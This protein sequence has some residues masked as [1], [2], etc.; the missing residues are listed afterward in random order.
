M[1]KSMQEQLSGICASA[2]ALALELASGLGDRIEAAKRGVPAHRYEAQ[3]RGS[4]GD[5]TSAAAMGKPDRAT[6]DGA[7]LEMAVRR[8]M[9]AMQRALEIA[10]WYSPPAPLVEAMAGEQGCDSCW[11]TYVSEGVRRWSPPF[12]VSSYVS[13]VLHEPKALCS[14]CYK[15]TAKVGRLPTTNE[16]E[17]HHSGLKIMFPAQ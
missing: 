13:G 10:D 4:M 15:F 14:W 17:R 5:P 6:T 7:Q 8:A 16:L 9:N 12:V 3:G 1:P 2:A 11:R